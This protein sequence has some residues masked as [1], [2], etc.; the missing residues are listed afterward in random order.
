MAR[1]AADVVEAYIVKQPTESQPVL[2]RVR[3]IIRK[4]LPGAEETISYRIPT[5]KVGGRGVVA[6][7]GWTRHWS[8]YPVTERVRAAFGSE[9]DGYEFSKGT[10]R[11]PL[12]APVPT[13]LVER[14]VRAV[15]RR[16]EVR[17]ETK[18]RTTSRPDGARRRTR[19]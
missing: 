13:K 16:A 5:Y 10:M 18:A 19:G 9:L 1:Q 4:V 8:L 15:A 3:R 17:R 11:F 6:Y 12:A 14:I 7:A 2:Q